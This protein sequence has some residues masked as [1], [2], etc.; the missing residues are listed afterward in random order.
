M[1]IERPF[2]ELR[3]EQR[4]VF[5]VDG[6]GVVRYAEYVPNVGQHPDYDGALAVLR[7][8]AGVG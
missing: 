5:V 8:L 6:Q 7:S 3:L 2:K 4:A 1:T